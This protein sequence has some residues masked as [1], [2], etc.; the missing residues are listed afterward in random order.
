[1]DFPKQEK[2]ILKFWKENKIFE[3]SIRRREK[4][5]DFVFYEGPPTAN[6]KAGIHHL[7]ARVFKDTICRYKTMRG[8]RVLRKA[9]WDTH[10]LP[11]E[12]EIEKK[13]GLKSKKDI[14]KY[15]IAKFNKQCR[16][17][18]W[19]YKQDWEKLTE[20]I[21]YWLDMKEPYITCDQNYIESVW[22]L[23]KQIWQKGLLEQDYKVVP[24]CP[25]CGTSLSSHEVA[26]GYKKI[27]EPSIYVKFPVVD[28]KNTY[29]LVWTTTPWTLPGN[30]AVAVNPKF[31]YA[32]VKVGDEYL[33]LAKKRIK[34]CKIE[35]KIAEEFNG[36]NLLGLQY[37]PLYQR[38]E[39]REQKTENIYKIIPGDFVSAEEGT[40]LVHIAPAFGEDDMAV[41]KK[42]NLPVLMTV[43]KN[44][45]LTSKVKQW[46]GMF[47]KDAD[48]LIILDLEK[49]NLL[50]KKEMY[51]HD[52]P[53]C[54]RC[55]T[56]LIYY[57]K[58]SWF[59][60]MTKFKKEIIKNN[61]KINWIPGHLKDGRFGEW[62]REL[63]DWAISRERFWGTPLPI[64]RCQTGKSCDN[65]VVI[66][67]KQDLLKQKFSTN[68]YYILRHGHSCRQ[69]KKILVCWPEKIRCP[70][71]EEG[72][73]QIG[74]AAKE[75]FN[76]KI[77]I[78]YSSDL[79]R[80]KQTAQIVSKKLGVKI[81]YDPRLR[82]TNFGIYN[83][84]LSAEV[85]KDFPENKLLRKRPPE[86]ENWPDVKKR[87][88]DFIKDIDKKHKNKNILIVSHGDPLML[89]EAAMRGLNNKEILKMNIKRAYVKPGEW[90]KI[91][92]KNL[93]YNKKME[94]DFH[95]PFIDEIKFECPKCRGSM[96]RV[97][98][99]I[100]CW[101]DAGAMP[102]AQAHWP[103]DDYPSLKPPT[104][105]PADYICEAVDQTRGWFYTLL[106]ISTL[107]GFGPSY[108]NVISVGHVLDE[109]GEKMSKSKGNVVNPWEMIEKYGS[110][111]VRWY[112]YTIN[113]PGDSKL[114]VEKDVEQSLKKFIMTFWNVF[115]FFETYVPK[116]ELSASNDKLLFSKNLLDKWIISKLNSL[117]FD[118]TE[119]LEKY[120]IT[121]A[122]RIIEDFVINNL[123]LWY[124]RRSRKRFQRPKNEK[125]L[126]QAAQ[127]L[128]FVLATLSRLSAPF[129][130]FLSEEIYKHIKSQNSVHLCGYPKA[131]KKLI[132][133][134]IIKN[135]KIAR[136]IVAE[137]LAQRAKAGLKVRQPLASLKIKNKKIKIK[138]NEELLNLIKDEIN[139]KEVVFNSKIKNQI[140]LDTKIT[141]ELKE[142]GLIRE[143]IR[144]IQEMRKK[145]GYKPRH[146]ILVRYS[147]SKKLDAI[148]ERNKNFIL[149]ETKTENFLVGD[150]PK[151][152]FDVEKE[153]TLDNEKLWLGIKKI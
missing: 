43:D 147:G 98:E 85:W 20:H 102:F 7:L 115:S 103:F 75:L 83:G 68:Q 124:V 69:K 52:Y 71:T 88:L 42:N 48:P 60:R 132:D 53:F 29:F 139:V 14:E 152:V 66:G 146:R 128:G 16:E 131:N 84:R 153:M 12:I 122:A 15:G 57:A 144:Q 51:E 55:K 5:S 136:E 145:A 148:L 89:L 19:R 56:P 76:K 1:M 74:K 70:L 151:R 100:D 117:I 8:F 50:F 65:V 92:F 110:D 67:S 40:G 138:D 95:R 90:R 59:I 73:K 135:M 119:K 99:V 33:I 54:W 91:D 96:K 28:K 87:T 11:V 140:E 118:A 77:D 2:K 130:P 22:W 79:L 23:L 143:V 35:G 137:A 129:I 116:K 30:V 27:K 82:D 10:G 121:S 142:E 141:P 44:G 41:G 107:L 58:K 134:K 125:E 37:Q 105:F 18:V 63:K 97:P 45:C 6:A 112:F 72:K 36:K 34:E 3:E 86:G 38:T 106:A 113:Q 111:A 62:L 9:G 49:K 93:P 126:E 94:L 17:S 46:A 133:K 109:K 64:W 26:Q 120:D 21:G 80:T 25:R 108:K 61:Q 39:N 127:T 114:F 31:V 81:K 150:K 24:Y 101:F 104:L 78:I 123:S 47:V 4:A 13:L 149:A 32:K